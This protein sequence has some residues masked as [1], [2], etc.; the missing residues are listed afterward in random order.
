MVKRN[1]FLCCDICLGHIVLFKHRH[2]IFLVWS[3][4]VLRE[5]SVF[6]DYYCLS[7]EQSLENGLFFFMK[8][9]SSVKMKILQQP[10]SINFGLIF[11]SVNWNYLPMHYCLYIT[12]WSWCCCLRLD[13]CLVANKCRSHLIPCS[14]HV[15]I[16]F[17]C[18]RIKEKAIFL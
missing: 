15:K 14:L 8:I 5:T 10:L 16:S 11:F 17:D 3:T 12:S 6:Q 18:R 9:F 13:I 4:W 1:L 7:S 2:Q